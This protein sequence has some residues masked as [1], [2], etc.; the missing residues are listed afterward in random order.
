MSYLAAGFLV[1]L[2]LASV[3]IFLKTQTQKPVFSSQL[4]PTIV[5][6]SELIKSALTIALPTS[7]TR[8]QPTQSHQ[9]QQGET[10]DRIAQN[11]G[12]S[13]DAIL[14]TNNLT[15]RDVIFAGQTLIIPASLE[16]T[17]IPLDVFPS[18]TPYRLGIFAPPASATMPVM[19]MLNG[20]SLHTLIVFPP[21]VQEHVQEI[22]SYGQAVGR[23]PHAFSKLGDS[24]IENPHF[25]DRFDTGMYNLG[26]Y[27]H[28]EPT[29]QHYAGS[30]SRHSIAVQRGLH[31]WSVFDPLWAD[32]RS[33]LPN[34]SILACEIRVHNPSIIFIRLGANDVG[35]PDSFEH[36][37][38]RI[39][40]HCIENGVIP[41]LGTKAD[42]NEGAGNINNNIV[43]K[44]A[45]EYQVPLWD[46]DLV[47]GTL[48]GRG[49][50]RDNVHMTTF[51]EYDYTLATAFERGYGVHNLLAL[52][53]LDAVRREIQTR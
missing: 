27:Q 21:S 12:V 26:L 48:P 32:S 31:S 28:L 24:T 38:R 10:L 29:V 8:T 46:F 33:C 1:T 53:T 9:V 2:I 30:Y 36:N 4:A 41:L 52:L 7:S 43:R 15:N 34:E 23:N 18:Q 25:L 22:Y 20:M 17:H 3:G 6:S 35:V 49:L 44:I 11:Y 5:E 47:A 39:I 14:T 13:T 16:S 50:G 19:E 42:R 40:E 45:E 37:M 51:F